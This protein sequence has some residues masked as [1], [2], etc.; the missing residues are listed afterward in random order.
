MRSTLVD[1]GLTHDAFLGGRVHLWQPRDG[2]R[3]GVDPVLLAA[4]VPAVS[5]QSVLEL[6]CGGGVAMACLNTRVAGLSLTGVEVQSAYAALAERNVPEARI[7]CAD[8]REMPG[9]LR[10]QSFDHV[11]ANPPFFPRA[12]H[13]AAR[14]AGRNA[15]RMELD[16]TISD[17]VDVMARRLRPRG[18]AHIIQRIERLPELLTACDARLGSLEVL[19][20]AGRIGRAAHLVIV[21][22]RKGGRAG[23]RLLPPLIL[24]EGAHHLDDR[25]SYAPEISAVLR[26]GAPLDWAWAS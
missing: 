21:R 11:I 26:D 22:A 18:F 10:Q 16:S 2:Y 12:S 15:G 13:T 17:W 23:F 14:D 4:S 5:G 19:P 6:G 24:H 20:I 25:D 7:V 9:D 8:L 3:A 1:D